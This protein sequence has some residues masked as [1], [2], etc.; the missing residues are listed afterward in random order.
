MCL[1]IL[2]LDHAVHTPL[3][4]PEQALLHEYS[5][6]YKTLRHMHTL[7]YSHPHDPEPLYLQ[8]IP[9]VRG[10]YAS[11][12]L[13]DTLHGLGGPPVLLAAAVAEDLGFLEDLIGLH[14]A[15]ADR[16][17]A[18]VDVL[19][20]NNGVLGRP[21]RNGELDLGVGGGELGE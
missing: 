16:L 2:F 4:Q 14:V 8:P 15:H 21:R 20:D 12:G 18:A 7:L 13:V 11:D 5:Y 19:C 3:L 17:F 10:P 6:C 9:V 1:S